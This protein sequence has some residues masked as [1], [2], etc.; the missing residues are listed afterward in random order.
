M[1]AEI[2]KLLGFKWDTKEQSDDKYI[3][4]LNDKARDDIIETSTNLIRLQ[5]EIK[6]FKEEIDKLAQQ[7]P[8]QG[9]KI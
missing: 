3:N 5:S 6:Q 7:V 2:R 9:K 8:Q 4:R 1:W